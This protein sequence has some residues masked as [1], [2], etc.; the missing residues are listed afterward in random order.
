M[1]S[2]RGLDLGAGILG[3]SMVCKSLKTEEDLVLGRKCPLIS[4][5][6]AKPR[7]PVN[8]C[9]MRSPFTVGHF[10][11]A[12]HSV[13]VCC[14]VASQSNNLEAD[15]MLEKRS[16]VVPKVFEVE[17]LLTE[18]CDTSIA[19]FELKLKG[20]K[21]YVKR[22]VSKLKDLTPLPADYSP[23]STSGKT[24]FVKSSMPLTPAASDPH[25]PK[26][27]ALSLYKQT[28]MQKLL[29][30]ADD[31]SLHFVTSPKVGLFRKARNKKGK[32]G[33]PMCVEGQTIKEGQVVCFVEQLGPQQPIQSKVAGEIVRILR[34]DGE[35]V[36]YGD[37]LI[38][39]LPSFPG[40]KKLD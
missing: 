16:C 31:E 33:R 37:P 23:V 18:I 34:E 20:F 10:R 19:E 3:R 13:H 12:M 8:M 35:P 6:W 11:K 39:I 29:D 27:A 14:W 30:S 25:N 36:G 32:W 24:E 38:S 2:L 26:A 28:T 4:S 1:A 9:A 5:T 40:I 17:P 22:D 21:L 15:D 7:P